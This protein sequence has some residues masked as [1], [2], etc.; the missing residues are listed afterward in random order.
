MTDNSIGLKNKYYSS[1]S[2]HI[3]DPSEPYCRLNLKQRKS[4]TKISKTHNS[5]D[6][7]EFN[8]PEKQKNSLKN[9][10]KKHGNCSANHSTSIQS[11]MQNCGKNKFQFLKQH[12][13][14]IDNLIEIA[15][16]F[17]GLIIIITTALIL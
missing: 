7:T 11:R 2:K 10:K 15:N 12:S 8:R 13:N 3:H 1:E 6:K 16:I 4:A 5:A 17:A 9:T 14:L